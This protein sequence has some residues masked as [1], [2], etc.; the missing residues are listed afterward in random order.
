[1]FDPQMELLITLLFGVLAEPPERTWAEARAALAASGEV[2]DELALVVECE[3]AGELRALLESYLSGA[4]HLPVH[5][6]EVLKR[7]LKAYRKRLK[8]TLLDAESSLGGGPFSG[9]RKSDIVGITPPARDPRAGWPE[10]VRQ[11]RRR[12]GGHG[13]DERAPQ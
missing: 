2:E 13:T 12:G 11:K 4:R 6:R 8:V 7:A 5:D 1:V 10:L 3:D 9:G